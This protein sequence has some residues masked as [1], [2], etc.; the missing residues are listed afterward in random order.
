[1]AELSFG[2]DLIRKFY[3]SNLSYAYVAQS[4]VQFNTQVSFMDSPALQIAMLARYH[5]SA[6]TLGTGQAIL[7]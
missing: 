7:A 1:M 6:E 5:P 4:T 3:L 2:S